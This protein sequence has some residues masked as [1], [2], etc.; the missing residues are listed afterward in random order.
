MLLD[1]QKRTGAL[2]E[3]LRLVREELGRRR[4]NLRPRLT[5]KA[6]V[7]ETHLDHQPASA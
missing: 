5:E 1:A 4:Q 2:P 7:D 3:A 6:A